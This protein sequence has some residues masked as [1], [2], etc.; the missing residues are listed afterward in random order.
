MEK[1]NIILNLAFKFCTKYTKEYC[2]AM[3]KPVLAGIVGFVIIF[4]SMTNQSL[5]LLSILSLPFIFYSFWQSY[6]ISYALIFAA[7]NLLKEN[8]NVPF[9]IFVERT[10]EKSS[11]LAFWVTFCAILSLILIVPGVTAFAFGA[12]AAYQNTQNA[13]PLCIFACILTLLN[14]L[15]IVPFLSYL[16]QVFYFKD[17]HEGYLSLFL[18]CYK[19]L[20]WTGIV[21]IIIISIFQSLVS[22][23]TSFLYP[24]FLLILNPYIYAANTYWYYGRLK[25]EKNFS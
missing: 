8:S 11:E 25:Q 9:K 15:F 10:K 17:E 24:L 6:L 21:L 1:L 4:V 14:A 20:D 16:N 3:I 13:I 19:R 23:F 18:N 12:I 5:A 7:M 22:S 2:L